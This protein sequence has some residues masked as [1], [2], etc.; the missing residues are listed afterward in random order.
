MWVWVVKVLAILDCDND[1]RL[2]RIRDEEYELFLVTYTPILNWRHEHVIR[3][4]AQCLFFYGFRYCC[5][6]SCAISTFATYLVS[7]VITPTGWTQERWKCEPTHG[8][9]SGAFAFM[10]LNHCQ[11]RKWR[12]WGIRCVF[13]F[14]LHVLFEAVLSFLY[15][16]HL[17]HLFN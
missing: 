10:L 9:G 13:H 16:F 12:Y 11:T 8:I 15:S 7:F 5:C 1:T 17:K 3:E 2:D 4:V 6:V 14:S